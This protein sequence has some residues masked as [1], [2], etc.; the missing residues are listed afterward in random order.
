MVCLEK[1]LNGKKM[2]Q[3]LPP[4][5]MPFISEFQD[6]IYIIPKLMLIPLFLELSLFKIFN[7]PTVVLLIV[8]MLLIVNLIIGNF[9]LSMELPLVI[10]SVLFLKLLDYL[11]PLKEKL[12]KLSKKLWLLNLC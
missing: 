3:E 11:V 2:D 9:V 8:L 12:K 7:L 6:T 4:L 1:I 10:G 5:L